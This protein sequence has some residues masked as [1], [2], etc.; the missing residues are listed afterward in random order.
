MATLYILYIILLFGMN[1]FYGANIRT[2]TTICAQFRIYS[3]NIA[4]RNSINRA[5]VNAT[6]TSCTIFSYY[7]SHSNLL[8]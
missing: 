3:I 7:V 1:S 8:F 6:S 2:C 5:F 4:L